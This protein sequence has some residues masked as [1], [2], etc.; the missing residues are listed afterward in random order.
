M[1]SVDIEKFFTPDRCQ[2]NP[3]GC[4]I[5]TRATAQG[6]ARCNIN[7][8]VQSV[9]RVILES[10][11][12]PIGSLLACHTCDNHPCIRPDHLFPGTHKDN[13]DDMM[14]KGRGGYRIPLGPSGVQGVSWSVQYGAWRIHHAFDG[15]AHCFGVFDKIAD[16]AAALEI[17][18]NLSLEMKRRLVKVKPLGLTV[19]V[20]AINHG[21]EFSSTNGYWRIAS[22]RLHRLGLGTHEEDPLGLAWCFIV[23]AAGRELAQSIGAFDYFQRKEQVKVN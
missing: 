3:D 18:R 1:N 22:R 19:L 23:N 6:Y 2:K 10:I 13:A 21:R 12:G 15:K 7:G 14:R 17:I 8:K 9:A 5:W 20:A 16:A 11:H 4:W